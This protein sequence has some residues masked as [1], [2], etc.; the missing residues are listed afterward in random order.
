MPAGYK[1]E[2]VAVQ[3]V[4]SVCLMLL[5]LTYRLEAFFLLCGVAGLQRA[6]FHV[7]PFAIISDVIHAEVRT[8]FRP[9]SRRKSF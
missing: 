8:V 5:A 6:V 3:L 1:L 7:V 4:L 9:V 2:F